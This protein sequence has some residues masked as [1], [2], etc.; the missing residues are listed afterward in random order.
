MRGST[1]KV[2]FVSVCRDYPNR[3][4]LIFS[5]RL[6]T[7]VQEDFWGGEGWSESRGE[8]DE[9]ANDSFVTFACLSSFLRSGSGKWIEPIVRLS[10][11][12]VALL[13]V[14]G[15][16]RG[17]KKVSGGDDRLNDS[18]RL[19]SNAID[20]YEMTRMNQTL[21]SLHFDFVRV[22]EREK[23]NSELRK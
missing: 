11:R 4:Q 20:L 1:T 19:R 18:A 6:A 21:I 16:G 23:I 15:G 10:T 9:N 22:P 7:R 17:Q 13:R 12:Q 8:K 2:T 3:R 14:E 5:E